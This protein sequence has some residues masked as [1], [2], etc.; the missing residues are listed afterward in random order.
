[1]REKPEDSELVLMKEGRS[2]AEQKVVEEVNIEE[3]ERLPPP[4]PL[5]LLPP[6]PPPPKQQ[7]DTQGDQKAAD[8]GIAI[9]VVA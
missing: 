1:M 7:V 9:A 8:C 5:P 6:T 3:L 4:L 2:G